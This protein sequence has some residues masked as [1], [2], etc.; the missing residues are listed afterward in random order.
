MLHAESQAVYESRPDHTEPYES[1]CIYFTLFSYFVFAS[2]N[3]CHFH[4]L[5]KLSSSKPTPR[6]IQHY[7]FVI[8]SS[9]LFFYRRFYWFIF[10]I[11]FFITNS[12]RLFLCDLTSLQLFI[13]G[14]LP[15][16]CVSESH[17]WLLCCIPKKKRKKD[18]R[19]IVV[20]IVTNT[21]TPTL[22]AY[23]FLMGGF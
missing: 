3:T 20:F 12:I 11:P 22:K 13:F 21:N 8:V 6:G 18:Y 14:S 1:N 2:Y 10:I 4:R 5:I 23:L 19:I 17:E 7:W 15:S 9:F 16:V